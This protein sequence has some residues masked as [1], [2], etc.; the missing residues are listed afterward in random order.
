MTQQDKNWTR[1]ETFSAIGLLLSATGLTVALI[2][3]VSNKDIRCLIA[4]IDCDKIQPVTVVQPS[5]VKVTQHNKSSLGHSNVDKKNTSIKKVDQ[6]VR[7]GVSAISVI[8]DYYQEINSRNY[9]S[10]WSRL[11]K[12]TQEN[13]PNGQKD[14]TTFFDSVSEVQSLK[15]SIIEST[16]TK[17]IINASFIY[18]MKRG[19]KAPIFLK[20][21][22]YR[23]NV[24]KDWKIK[25]I[26]KP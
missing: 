25:E 26:I 23:E 2:S 17:A 8:H 6:I 21:K 16:E 18:I 13:H 10:A 12:S 5:T 1:G 15:L 4:R 22:V 24:D 7:N 11:P 19:N 14:F 20:Y 9:N 3:A